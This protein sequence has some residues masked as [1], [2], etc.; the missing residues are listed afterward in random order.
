MLWL[1]LLGIVTVLT[2]VVR[3][4]LQKQKPLTDE[5][6]SKRLAID[7][8]SSGVAWVP[9]GGRLG[10]VNLSLANL[11]SASAEQLAGRNWLEIFPASERS[12]LEE[13]YRQML[14]AGI[15]SID[16]VTLDVRGVATARSVVL[17]AV[18]DHRTRLAGHHCI[19][20]RCAR[21][22]LRLK[23]V[24]SEDLQIPSK[25]A[26]ASSEDVRTA[27]ANMSY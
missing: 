14:L 27:F 26:G 15:A 8:V 5:L 1:Y 22:E 19:I 9:A 2:I 23:D 7:H 6:Y 13:A 25:G 17:V 21:E 20:E 4:L 3:R 12:R 11:L 18:H 16:T 24:R 10:S